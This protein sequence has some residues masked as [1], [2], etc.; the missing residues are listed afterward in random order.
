EPALDPGRG[1][2]QREHE[3][4]D[5]VEGQHQRLEGGC[6][7]EGNCWEHPDHPGLVWRGNTIAEWI[8]GGFTSLFHRTLDRLTRLAAGAPP[9]IISSATDFREA[10]R[11]R[12]PPFLF[13][14][15]DGGSGAEQTLRANV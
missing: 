10:A 12:L 6:D 13:H 2:A 5:Q 11:R 3:G 1:A 7:V 4:A 9:M 14:Y 8:A 15:L